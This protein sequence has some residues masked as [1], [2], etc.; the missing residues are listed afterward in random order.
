MSENQN[1][2][3]IFL[4]FDP[5]D[6]YLV[7]KIIIQLNNANIRGTYS[8]ERLFY[9]FRSNIGFTDFITSPIKSEDYII[10]VCSPAYFA[11]YNYA[12]ISILFAEKQI[13]P[14][15]SSG[16]WMEVSPTWLRDV[17]YYDIKS[18]INF[19]A[20]IFSIV[21]LLKKPFKKTNTLSIEM[22]IE[23]DI[24]SF[25]EF[26][27]TSIFNELGYLL[28]SKDIR[29]V[30]ISSGSTKIL[31]ELPSEQAEVLIWL[32]KHHALASLSINDAK[33]IGHAAATAL[34]GEKMKREHY[35]VFLC[36]NSID[37]SEVKRIAIQLRNK[38]ILPWVDEWALRPGIAWQKVLEEQII[39]INSVAI[40]LGSNGMGPWQDMELN[41]FIRQFVKRNCPVIP[42]I[43]K[44][45][46]STPQV[47]IFLEGMTWVDFRKKNPDPYDQLI[48]GITG[49]RTS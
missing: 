17:K 43:L 3:N 35:D 26:D 16:D 42:V 9:T 44:S 12:L 11:R 40:C 46:T 1:S 21:D 31:I 37:K 45:C 23:R 48:W 7:N 20:G 14:V 19:H 27:L 30:R 22:K 49:K 6:A 4:S 39:D 2:R 10:V 41:A 47:P 5:S 25:S 33:I 32:Y 15:L 24:F 29:L 34:I 36:H 38:G 13:I 18:T 8:F 28:E